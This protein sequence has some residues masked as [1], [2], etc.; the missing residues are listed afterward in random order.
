[1]YEELISNF[2]FLPPW[3]KILNLKSD[4]HIFKFLKAKFGFGATRYDWS[5]CLFF[6][7]NQQESLKCNLSVILFIFYFY[8]YFFQLF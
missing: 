5:L 4:E 8:F 3:Q 6:V 1:M 2:G 7:L